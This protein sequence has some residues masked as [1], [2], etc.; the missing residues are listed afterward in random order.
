MNLSA[1]RKLADRLTRSSPQARAEVVVETKPTVVVK[2]GRPRWTAT[3]TGRIVFSGSPNGKHSLDVGISDEAR[4]RA[5]W[6]GYVASVP[7]NLRWYVA[8]VEGST[9]DPDLG[10]WHRVVGWVRVQAASEQEAR[11]LARKT[12]PKLVTWETEGDAPDPWSVVA[13]RDVQ[14]ERSTW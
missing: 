13:V 9:K 6:N 11:R 3:E 1:A 2:G 8:T 14:E 4:V 7:V 12:P 10:R 5:H